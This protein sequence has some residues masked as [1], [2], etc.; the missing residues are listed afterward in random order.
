M[1]YNVLI[2]KGCFHHDKKQQQ[3]KTEKG[4]YNSISQFELYNLQ[5][6]VYIQHDLI[7]IRMCLCVA[8]PHIDIH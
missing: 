8:L 3:K 7:S 4:N 1:T 2:V 5:L 6:R